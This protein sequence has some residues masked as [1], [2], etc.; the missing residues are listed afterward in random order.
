MTTPRVKNSDPGLLSEL[1][2]LESSTPR[3]W[4]A[5]ELGAVLRHQLSAP[6]RVELAQL[7]KGAAARLSLIAARASRTNSPAE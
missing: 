5:Q 2:G 3:A 1:I 7:N 4:N 6:V